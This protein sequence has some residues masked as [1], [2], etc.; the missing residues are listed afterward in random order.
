MFNFNYIY[1]RCT[2]NCCEIYIYIIYMGMLFWKQILRGMKFS[3][4]LRGLCR[5]VCSDDVWQL[6]P[7]LHSFSPS[8]WSRAVFH[9]C[10]K[11]RNPNFLP[12]K[13]K[14]KQWNSTLESEDDSHPVRWTLCETVDVMIPIISKWPC[15]NMWSP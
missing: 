13:K 2:Y 8:C 7:Q 6:P 11:V 10:C 14:K 4:N 3:E 12:R 9:R 5:Q 15:W 1:F